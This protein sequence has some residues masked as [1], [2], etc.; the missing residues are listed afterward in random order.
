MIPEVS[1]K[2]GLLH[3]YFTTPLFLRSHLGP[4]ACPSTW[5]LCAGVLASSWLSPSIC[6]I[7]LT[8]FSAFS[9][10]ICLEYGSLLD[11]LACPGGGSSWLCLVDHLPSLPIFPIILIL[12]VLKPRTIYSLCYFYF[13]VVLSILVV[14]YKLFNQIINFSKKTCR[15][16]IGIALNMYPSLQRL[17]I[18]TILSLLIDK[19]Y[20]FISVFFCFFSAIYCS[21]Q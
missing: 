1:G 4:R 15:I 11:I 2:S 12:Q 19:H 14:S 6:I 20:S 21:F 5:Q 18:L 16:L 9:Q 7:S 17:R 10:M 3:I 8:I 13:K